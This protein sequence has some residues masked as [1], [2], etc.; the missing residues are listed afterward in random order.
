MKKLLITLTILLAAAVAAALTCPD[1]QA[2]L[3]AIKAVVN[4]SITDNLDPNKTEGQNGL[5]S[6]IGSL[7]ADV[8]GALLDTRLTVKDWRV[9]SIGKIKDPKGV[10]HTVSAGV[11][12]HVFTFGKENLEKAVK[13]EN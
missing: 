7:G 12:G 13:G 1:R 9:C 11:F 4:E 6:I 8:A 5:A 2:H 10:E 3:D